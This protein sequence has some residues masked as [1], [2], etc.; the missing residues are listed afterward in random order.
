MGWEAKA[1]ESHPDM[2]K[3]RKKLGINLI[4][5]FMSKNQAR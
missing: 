2:P 5:G 3:V 1:E 4:I